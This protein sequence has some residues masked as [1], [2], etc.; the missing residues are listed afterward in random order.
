M[1]NQIR[2][3][4]KK[5]K[6]LTKKE[7]ETIGKANIDNFITCTDLKKEIDSLKNSESKGSTF[8]FV[9]YKSKIVS[10]GQLIPLK[11]RYLG[12]GYNLF[13]I[14]NMISIKKGKGYGKSLVQAMKDFLIKKQKTG[15]GFC[16]K[17]NVE[18]YKKSGLIVEGKLKNRFFYDYGNSKENKDAMQDFVLYLEGKDKFPTKVLKTKSL[19]KIPCEHW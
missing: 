5:G 3:E 9:K 7:I 17:G 1:K 2:V 19:V 8:F 4:I 6:E 16:H 11:I 12:K 14:S 18:F 13:G 10:L 15:L